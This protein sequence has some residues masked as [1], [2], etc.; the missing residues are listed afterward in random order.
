M[1]HCLIIDG[2]NLAYR[3]QYKFS[4]S[5]ATGRKSSVAYGFIYILSSMI[6]R[7]EPDQVHVVFDGGRA[8][9]R[10]DLLPT[11]KAREDKLG[12]DKQAFYEQIDDLEKYLPHLGIKVAR[13][14]GVEADDTIGAIALSVR[15]VKITILSSDKDFMQLVSDKV[16]VFNPFKDTLI[17]PKNIVKEYGFEAHEIVDWLT[18]KGDKSDHIPGVSGLGDKRIRALLD[19]FGSV[20]GFLD[21]DP[22]TSFERYRDAIQEIA[23]RNFKLINL[24]YAAK[25][26]YGFRRGKIIRFAITAGKFD[27]DKVRPF[28]G[29]YQLNKFRRD[30]FFET[31]K[32]LD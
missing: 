26:L 19:E 29:K 13:S 23:S 21:A 6:K 7:F 1:R 27:E 17:T 32:R 12:E 14:K 30:G 31:F 25:V 18:L 10:T 2:Y 9:F 20:E 15:G 4:L 5:T 11:Y 22:D 16:R 24:R 28:L 3:A 8:K